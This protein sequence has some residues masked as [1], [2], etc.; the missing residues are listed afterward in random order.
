MDYQ[1]KPG[2]FIKDRNGVFVKVE[3]I[4]DKL[5]IL[6][7]SPWVMYVQTNSGSLDNGGRSAPD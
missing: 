7:N 1:K 4:I 2:S 6:R 5:Q 3:K